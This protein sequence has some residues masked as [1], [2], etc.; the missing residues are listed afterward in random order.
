MLIVDNRK[1][2]RVSCRVMYLEKSLARNGFEVSNRS[3]PMRRMMR[4]HNI[5]L[6]FPGSC[7]VRDTNSRNLM[8]NEGDTVV[9]WTSSSSQTSGPPGH[10][11]SG[12]MVLVD[13]ELLQFNTSSTFQS[14]FSWSGAV[15]HYG[16]R[17]AWISESDFRLHG[18]AHVIPGGGI[19]SSS[20]T[21]VHTLWLYRS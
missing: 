3:R 12:S 11:Q 16:G 21:S 19:A 7:I 1:S 8:Y 20:A 14:Y 15:S 4:R 6:F 5:T 18:E 2:S 17:H 13:C 9:G 10:G